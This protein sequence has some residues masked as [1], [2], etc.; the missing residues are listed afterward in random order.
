VF[1][2]DPKPLGPKAS[3]TGFVPDTSCAWVV[4]YAGTCGLP[5]CDKEKH[6]R[7]Y[8]VPMIGWLHTVS[9]GVEF[10]PAVMTADGLVGDYLDIPEHY[11]F[12]G[13]LQDTENILDIA[14]MLYHKRYGDA[15]RLDKQVSGAMTN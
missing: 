3:V 10:R 4:V 8:V 9:D 13:V 1:A 6:D 14:Q 2:G 12:V 7:L 11:K 5:E 15:A